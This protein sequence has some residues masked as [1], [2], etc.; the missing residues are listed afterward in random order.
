MGSRQ[1]GQR[2]E[3]NNDWVNGFNPSPD[4]PPRL[5]LPLDCRCTWSS[6]LGNRPVRRSVHPWPL[7]QPQPQLVF[8]RRPGSA[9]SLKLVLREVS[10]EM[11]W[12]GHKDI[13]LTSVTS[14]G[15]SND[16]T[17]SY[18]W[19][20][21]RASAARQQPVIIMPYPNMKVST[22]MIGKLSLKEA[23]QLRSREIMRRCILSPTHGGRRRRCRRRR[24]RYNRQ[25][26]PRPA[27]TSHASI[28][29]PQ[30]YQNGVLRKCYRLCS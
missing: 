16:Q 26:A 2:L 18:S 3:T 11:W 27:G 21:D 25:P 23:L 10:V 29:A 4:L 13:L 24:R 5:S 12:L 15:A 8:H 22:R 28:V 7:S 9:H 14:S 20:R 30:N 6:S 19:T 1:T 17:S